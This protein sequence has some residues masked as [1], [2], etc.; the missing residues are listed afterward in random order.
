[1][2]NPLPFFPPHPQQEL[3][4]VQQGTKCYY[5]PDLIAEGDEV[6]EIHHGH[7]GRGPK[8]GRFMLIHPVNAEPKIYLAHAFCGRATLATEVCEEEEEVRLC[9]ECSGE[10]GDLPENLCM[11]CGVELE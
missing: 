11:A 1:M 5:C 3:A 10:L 4:P 7:L 6:V 2:S 9:H 8:S